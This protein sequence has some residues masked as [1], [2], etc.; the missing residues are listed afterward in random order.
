MQRDHP[1]TPSSWINV[2]CPD[3]PQIITGPFSEMLDL[4]KPEREANIQCGIVIIIRARVTKFGAHTLVPHLGTIPNEWPP[5][6]EDK[7]LLLCRLTRK[8][9]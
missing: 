3:D 7:H 5:S 6:T 9:P 1:G 2:A 8:T 4:L